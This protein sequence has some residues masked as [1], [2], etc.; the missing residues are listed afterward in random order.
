M[1]IKG[2]EKRTI[3]PQSSRAPG[4]LRPAEVR[5]L[6]QQRVACRGL[7]GGGGGGLYSKTEAPV[8]RT[9]GE[10]VTHEAGI[11]PDCAARPASCR[12]KARFLPLHPFDKP[13]RRSVTHSPVVSVRRVAFGAG[14]HSLSGWHQLMIG[15]VDPNPVDPNLGGSLS[16]FGDLRRAW[17]TSLP[18][19]ASPYRLEGIN[20]RTDEVLG[21]GMLPRTS[22]TCRG[23]LSVLFS[24]LLVWNEPHVLDC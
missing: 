6:L 3:A 11:R 21:G 16:D 1:R 20:S 5:G 12:K 2:E 8:C 10:S 18:S 24:A 15:F 23:A 4:G 19:L 22:M 14:R 13:N 9:P 17:V 7:G